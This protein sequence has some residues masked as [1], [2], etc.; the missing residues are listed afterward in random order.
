M[1]ESNKVPEDS[2]TK[3]EEVKSSDGEDAET[4]GGIEGADQ[5]LGYIICFANAVKLYQTKTRIVLNVAVLA[6]LWKIAWR[7][8]ARVLKK[9]V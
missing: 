7:I 1:V 4:K 5:W 9:W 3:A 6:I 8:S 2:G